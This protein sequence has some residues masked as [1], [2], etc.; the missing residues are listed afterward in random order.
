MQDCQQIGRDLLVPIAGA[1]HG[2][3]IPADQLM[4]NLT[5]LLE[6][7]IIIDRYGR[8]RLERDHP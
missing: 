1:G 7:Q 2:I 8:Q 5:C 4:T 6:S 3:Q